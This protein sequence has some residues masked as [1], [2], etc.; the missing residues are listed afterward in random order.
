M[1]LYISFEMQRILFLS[2]ESWATNNF[3]EIAWH[4]KSIE[5]NAYNYSWLMQA[6]LPH[7]THIDKNLQSHGWAM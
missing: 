4:K 1:I 3:K 2:A 6:P 7:E 5:S